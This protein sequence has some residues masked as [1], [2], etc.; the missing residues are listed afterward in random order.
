[1]T[2]NEFSNIVSWYVETDDIAN[3][4]RVVNYLTKLDYHRAERIIR[5]CDKERTRQLELGMIAPDVGQLI[6]YTI[7]A[8]PRQNGY[9]NRVGRLDFKQNFEHF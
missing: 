4:A 7:K 3:A 9:L 5:L 6:Y 1:M 8:L 2:R